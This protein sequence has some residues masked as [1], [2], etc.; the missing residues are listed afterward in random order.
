MA[1]VFCLGCFLFFLFFFFFFLVFGCEAH[2]PLDRLQKM[3]I[4]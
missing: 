3:Y 1:R 4:K 2:E